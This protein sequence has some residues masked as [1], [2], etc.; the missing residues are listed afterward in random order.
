MLN[1]EYFLL[2]NFWRMTRLEKAL[3]PKSNLLERRPPSSS[4]ERTHQTEE[5]TF[6]VED[7]HWTTRRDKCLPLKAQSSTRYELPKKQCSA[8]T[9]RGRS[10]VHSARKELAHLKRFIDSPSYREDY[11]R[12][13]YPDD[14]PLTP[15][16]KS[17][18]RMAVIQDVHRRLENIQYA[19]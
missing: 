13:Y 16:V 11:R 14:R 15:E 5:N 10:D 6:L 17:R 3:M 4:Q 1:E 7:T 9:R 8:D 19:C 18:I 12:G 2:S